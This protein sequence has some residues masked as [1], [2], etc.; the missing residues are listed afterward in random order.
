M[1]EANKESKKLSVLVYLIDKG[2]MSNI[3]CEKCRI[4]N[5]GN[6]PNNELYKCLTCNKN[7]CLLCRSNHNL[8][9]NI[10]KY[11]QKNYIYQKHN[12]PFIKYCKECNKNICYSCDE[13]HGKHNTIFLGD[14]K[15]DIEE[16]K[17]H[18]LEIK[19]R[20]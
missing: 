13:E 14:L 1:N 19:K 8:N 3:I 9:H 5:K 12:E 17:N 7:L 16:T 6:E 4:K 2:N 15:L 11:E 18:L 10:I 20:N